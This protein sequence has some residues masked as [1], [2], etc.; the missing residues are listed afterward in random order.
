VIKGKLNLA[1]TLIQAQYFIES[2]EQMERKL[3]PSQKKER[4]SFQDFQKEKN[5]NQMMTPKKA[6][7]GKRH[8]LFSTEEWFLEPLTSE[9]P[10]L[11]W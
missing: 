3:I 5:R 1:D 6:E 7:W 2:K 8:S 4:S 10:E 9:E 11:R